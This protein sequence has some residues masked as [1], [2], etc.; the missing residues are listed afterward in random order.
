MLGETM[1]ILSVAGDSGR[2]HYPGTLFRPA[3]A[4]QGR[5]T[6]RNTIYSASIAAGLMLHQFTR[7]LRGIP[8]DIDLTFNL[9]ASE[10]SDNLDGIA[11][12]RR[13]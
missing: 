11:A 9:L 5:C 2:S 13:A 10:L 8:V 1:R 3:D 6:A 12:L 7:W 4:Q